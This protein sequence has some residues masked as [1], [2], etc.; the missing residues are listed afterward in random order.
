VD[1]QFLLALKLSDEPRSDAMLEDLATRVLE[2]AGYSQSVIADLLASFRAA[3]DEGEGIGARA[4][5]I[6]FRVERGQLLVV[7][8]YAGGVE[9]RIGRALPD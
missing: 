1:D 4:C 5:D 6:E 8:S 2:H 3:L 7:V 9:R